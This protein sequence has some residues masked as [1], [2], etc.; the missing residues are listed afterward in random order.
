MNSPLNIH[1]FIIFLYYLQN[2]QS[3]Q[4]CN[5]KLVGL[6]PFNYFSF[7]SIRCSQFFFPPQ[8]LFIFNSFLLANLEITT[9]SLMLKHYIHF[10]FL[11]LLTFIYTAVRN[12][13]AWVIP[14]KH[15]GTFLL[16]LYL[17]NI[18]NINWVHTMIHGLLKSFVVV[19]A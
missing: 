13:I 1:L 7:F 19:K 10:D 5:F 15:H 14:L 17:S 16:F 12:T 3:I 8:S 11:Y 4:N 18:I 2:F 9:H 6:Y